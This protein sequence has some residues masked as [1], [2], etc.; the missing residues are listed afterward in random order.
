MGCKGTGTGIR[1]HRSSDAENARVLSENVSRCNLDLQGLGLRVLGLRSRG[2]ALP[3]RSVPA[4]FGGSCER[5]WV[6][7]NFGGCTFEF[8]VEG[9]GLKVEG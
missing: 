8:S 4:P 9:L 6:G 1:V 5:N 2:W 7:V 3:L